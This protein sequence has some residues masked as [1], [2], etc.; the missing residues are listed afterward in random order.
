[1]FLGLFALSLPEVDETVIH[2]AL[3]KSTK[4]RRRANAKVQPIGKNCLLVPPAISSLAP[5]I[6]YAKPFLRGTM[7]SHLY[8]C[9]LS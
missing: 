4:D 1:M 9:Y 6:L 7:V 2:T 3:Y 8:S 5:L